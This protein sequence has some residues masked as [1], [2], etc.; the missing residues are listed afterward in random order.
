MSRNHIELTQ[1]QWTRAL[2]L[3]DLFLELAGLKAIFLASDFIRS[4]FLTSGVKAR[5]SVTTLVILIRGLLFITRIARLGG[6]HVPILTLGR[7][8]W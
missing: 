8:V 7:G 5:S 4:T 1:T 6:E 3:F 2:L